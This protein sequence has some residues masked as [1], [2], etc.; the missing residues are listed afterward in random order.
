M[1]EGEEHEQDVIYVEKHYKLILQNGAPTLFYSFGNVIMF[2][3]F[4]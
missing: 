3:T 2:G 4:G 1:S